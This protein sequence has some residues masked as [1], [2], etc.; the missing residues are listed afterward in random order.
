MSPVVS[1]SW[2][3][4]SHLT[5]GWPGV[6]SSEDVSGGGEVVQVVAS[7]K[8]GTEATVRGPVW[9]G[10]SLSQASFVDSL[11]SVVDLWK[12]LEGEPASSA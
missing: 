10:V 7:G 6:G 4:L 2:H 11:S 5:Q 9:L 12:M 8:R 3:F 1:A